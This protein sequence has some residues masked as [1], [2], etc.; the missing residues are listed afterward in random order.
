MISSL[1]FSAEFAAGPRQV[2]A[3]FTSPILLRGWLCD[4]AL[5][6]RVQGNRYLFC[7]NNGYAAMGQ[8]TT[9][10]APDRV[11]FSW[12]GDGD[13][14]ATTVEVAITAE[15][16]GSRI[17]LT[18]QGLGE[19]DA[20]KSSREAV[21]RGWREGLDNLVYFLDTGLDARIMR[22]PM[23]GINIGFLEEGTQERLGLP[24][25]DGV[26]LSGTVEG[27]GAHNAGLRGGDLVVSLARHSLKSYSEMAAA[28]VGKKGGDT[29]DIAFYRGAELHQV[30]MRLSERPRPPILESVAALAEHLRRT[31]GELTGELD[32]LLQDVSA[33]DAAAR[34]AP[35]S[36]SVNENLAHLIFTERFTQMLNFGVMGGDDHIAWPDNN[37]AQ[38]TPILALYPDTTA[39]V[40]GLKREMLAT[41]VQVAALPAQTADDLPI[42]TTISQSMMGLADHAR[43]H[44]QQMREALEALKAAHG[45]K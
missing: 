23:L 32:A 8:Y 24:T 39:L 33:A 1:Q 45:V 38:L 34:P 41:V 29:V 30:Q 37:A 14:A 25:S 3:A 28:L 11:V 35:E 43:E 16:T 13:P 2:Y 21:E 20:W 18:H 9:L 40:D 42:F 12:M 22:R 44:Y 19:G 26:L 7:W 27:L 31:A 17:A 4:Y 10:Q 6:S 36:W 5:F 15:G